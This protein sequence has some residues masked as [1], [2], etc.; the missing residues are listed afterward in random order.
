[1]IRWLLGLAG[2]VL[3]TWLAGIWLLDDVPAV[4]L[5][6]DT[7]RTV[8]APGTVY[9]QRSEG[10]AVTR[11]G[12]LGVNG[13][14]DVTRVAGPKIVI[15]G[16][17][18][19]EAL[20]VDDQDKAAQVLTR[21]LGEAGLDATAFAVAGGGESPADHFF[22]LPEYERLVPNVRAH[23][24]VLGGLTDVKPAGDS[25]CHSRFL[26]GPPW[27]ERG[28]CL[29]SG[30]ALRLTPV[31]D[32]WRLSWAYELYKN[33]TSHQ[34]RFLPGPIT[35]ADEPQQAPPPEPPIRFWNAMLDLFQ[36]QTDLPLVFVYLPL[37]PRLEQGRVALDSDPEPLVRAFAQACADHGVG[38]VDMTEPFIRFYRENGAFVHGFAN[39]PPG[40]G[41]L[42]VQG[43]R[44]LAQALLDHFTEHDHVLRQP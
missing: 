41:H 33:L 39:T 25:Q 43:Q 3:L 27:I 2:A 22:L 36:A 37:V 5:D 23:V 29:P 44:L 14:E 17:S 19:V 26:D 40:S 12:R 11:V 9:H 35:K 15:W 6:P 10:W 8:K 1:M 34:F 21:E 38:F 4:I 13:I 18:F 16:D 20:Q 32:R 28:Q 24:L 7:G 30:A 31:M 42:N